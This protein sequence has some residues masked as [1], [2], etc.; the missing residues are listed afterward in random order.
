MV[1]WSFV[2]SIPQNYHFHLSILDSSQVK[3]TGVRNHRS[4][5]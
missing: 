4:R 2:T 5:D 3:Y 1:S